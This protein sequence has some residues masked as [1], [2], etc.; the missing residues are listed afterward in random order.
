MM[1]VIFGLITANRLF[2]ELLIKY[3]PAI[4]SDR[5]PKTRSSTR[6]RKR[7]QSDLSNHTEQSGLSVA[8]PNETM[9]R[10][11]G[12]C[13]ADRTGTNE[14]RIGKAVTPGRAANCDPASWGE[15]VT[16]ALELATLGCVAD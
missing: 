3:D 2:Q 14:H 15:G 1:K 12:V 7:N 13:V 9:P 10:R 5:E 4:Q 11:H 6:S 8:R 16:T